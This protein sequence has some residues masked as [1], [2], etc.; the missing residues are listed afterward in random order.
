MQP[1]LSTVRPSG[2]PISSGVEMKGRRFAMAPVAGSKQQT[3]FSLP[4]PDRP[5]AARLTALPARQHQRLH[6]TLSPDKTGK[7]SYSQYQPST[8]PALLHSIQDLLPIYFS[9]PGRVPLDP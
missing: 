9:R 6:T 4:S 1:S 3:P 7:S 8:V 5:R 2:V